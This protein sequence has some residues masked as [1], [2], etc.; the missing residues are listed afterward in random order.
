MIR[1]DFISWWCRPQFLQPWGRRASVLFA[2]PWLGEFGWELLNWQAFLR[3]LAPRYERVV[4]C[5]RRGTEA[6]YEDFADQIVHHAVRGTSD[7]NRMLKVD[8]PQELRRAE[9]LAPVDADVVRSVGW[10]PNARKSFVAFGTA[11]PSIALDVVMHARGRTHGAD[12]NWDASRWETLVALLQRDG[13]RLGCIGLRGATVALPETVTDLRDLPLSRTMDVVASVPLVIG[14][15]SGPMHL[16]SLCRTPHVVWTD[17]QRYARGRTNR[18]KYER[19]WNP[20]STPAYVLD[21]EGFDPR[22]PTVR[23][24]V[25]RALRLAERHRRPA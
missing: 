9:A 24:A 23:R 10:Q 19:W 15:S 5:A 3:W 25:H 14:P 21:D 1:R 4:V 11:D 7:C 13:L 17:R 2:G 22:P 20:L 16:A 8:N 18:M 12:R 6:L